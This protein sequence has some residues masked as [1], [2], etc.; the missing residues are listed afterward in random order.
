[1]EVYYNALLELS[2][3]VPGELIMLPKENS[4]IKACKTSL[5]SDCLRRES[6]FLASTR[7]VIAL[8]V[9]VCAFAALYACAIA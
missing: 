2:L 7:P 4:P 5:Y 8:C 3:K 1:M 9:C 6:N